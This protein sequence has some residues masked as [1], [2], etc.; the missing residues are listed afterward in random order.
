MFIAGCSPSWIVIKQTDP[1]P[2]KNVPSF[3]V[4][5]L[6]FD[7]LRVG[8]QS[9]KDYLG[10]L[11]ETRRENWS[12]GKEA[13]AASFFEQL[14]RRVVG[15]LV[16]TDVNG[17]KYRVMSRITYIDPGSQA[18]EA[19]QSTVVQM[20]ATI[21]NK[22]GE[23]LDEIKLKAK[24]SSALSAASVKGRLQDAATQLGDELASY[25]M[26]RAL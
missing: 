3:G 26:D 10:T 21:I 16:T 11:D 19:V 25:L 7:G 1:N 8:E 9:E 17:E 4:M 18:E 5:P 23:V 2:F 15:F 14:K 24:V 12:K 13:M 22:E 20:D 6:D